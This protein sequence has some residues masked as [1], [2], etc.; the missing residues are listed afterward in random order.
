MSVTLCKIGAAKYNFV[1]SIVAGIP[2]LCDGEPTGIV[3]HLI[4]TALTS[5]QANQN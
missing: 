3:E 5:S 1:T 2:S 4:I